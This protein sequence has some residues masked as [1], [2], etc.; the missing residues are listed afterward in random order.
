MLKHT[1]MFEF[2]TLRNF[3]GISEI[4]EVHE[5]NLK[6]NCRGKLTLY[7]VNIQGHSLANVLG[8]ESD[9]YI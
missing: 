1:A 4:H 9:P 7:S 5:L 6:G 3:K 8:E 2:N